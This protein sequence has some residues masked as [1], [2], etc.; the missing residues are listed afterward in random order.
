MGRGGVSPCV[1]E[2]IKDKLKENAQGPA[3]ATGDQGSM[4]QH[5]LPDQIEADRYLRD[6][7]T[8]A[9]KKLPLRFGKFRAGGA[10]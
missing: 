10:A 6:L 1:A 3:S 4:S 9:K 2:T 7:D 5:S 8:H